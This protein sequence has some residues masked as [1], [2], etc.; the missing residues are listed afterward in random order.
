M[1]VKYMYTLLILL[2]T[3]L[4]VWS[5]PTQA[6]IDGHNYTVQWA[7]NNGDV[8][9]NALYNAVAGDTASDGTRADMDRV[10]ILLKG[11]VYWNTE[12]MQNN[13]Y[14]LR[15]VGEDPDPNDQYG[16]P[17]ILQLVTR[18]DGS[19][20]SKILVG[21]GGVY[22]KNIYVIGSDDKGVQ[23]NYYQPIEFSANNLRCVFDNC[24]FER[25]N[26]AI[27]AWQGSKNNTIIFTNC[28]W[29]NLVERPITQ[30][31][32]G[33]G[34]SIWADQ[35]T[36]IVE[37]CTMDNVGFTALQLEG[38]AA[39]YLR[40]NHN[41]IIN[42]GRG[43]IS[44]PWLREAYFANNLFI[45]PFF[46][47]EGYADYNPVSNPSRYGYYT[48]FFSFS[49]IPSGYGT[50]LARRIL[51]ANNAAFLAQSFKDA[52]ADTIRIQPFTSVATDSFFTYYSPTNADHPG[53]MV[54]KDTTWLSGLP[55]FTNYDTTNYPQMI[56]FIQDIRAGITPAPQWMQDLTVIGT[57]TIWT[58][59]QWPLVQNFA[60]TDANLLTAGTDGLPL[61]DLN[62]FPSQKADFETNKDQYIKQIEG[63]S[64]GRINDDVVWE[65]QAE[66]GTLADGATVVPYTGPS[67]YTLAAG[68]NIEW[69]FNSTYAGL[70][71]V[72]MKA[73]ADGANIGFDFVLNGHT[74]VD[75]ARGWGQ[76]VVWTGPDDPQ[77]FW[78]GKSTSRV[79]RSIIRYC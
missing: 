70:F 21:S 8:I 24:I 6:Q 36:V 17:A 27:T 76:F 55:N 74:I 44:A 16:F 57:D 77:T 33:R 68:T 12:H 73:R 58:A 3:M 28:K 67:W 38:G 61:G 46:D 5:P 72:T 45:N 10:Y 40:F 78:S 11:G 34:I 62:W 2:G 48:G 39:K 79:L 18:T 37:N 23:S 50:D 60:Y 30:Q 9:V 25:A 19:A 51:F 1:K 14:T 66:D 4:F 41:T 26:F 32:T 56:Q 65:G 31:W 75:A 15:L 13:G 53:Q 49:T 43:I 52:W 20:D 71:D 47:G 54:I 35:D 7:D 59:P 64:G 69:A 42:L 22:F 29:Y 63:M